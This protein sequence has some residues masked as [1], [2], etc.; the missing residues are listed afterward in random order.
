[1]AR[2][3]KQKK[4]LEEIEPHVLPLHGTETQPHGISPPAPGIN[5]LLGS[6]DGPMAEWG[7]GELLLNGSLDYGESA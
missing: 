6:W 2:W 1:M 3:G 4:C 7:P 5:G